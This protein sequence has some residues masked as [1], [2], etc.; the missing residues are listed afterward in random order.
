[1]NE[2]DIDQ[3]LI[4]LRA[5]AIVL[6]ARKK[7]MV[8]ARSEVAKIL[9][10]GVGNA[11]ALRQVMLGLGAGSERKPILARLLGALGFRRFG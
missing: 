6:I 5:A 11:E 7:G 4:D 8:V 2:S 1:M 3:A 9:E 10:R